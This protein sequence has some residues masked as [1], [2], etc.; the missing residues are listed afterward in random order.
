[1]AAKMIPIAHWTRYAAMK[2]TRVCLRLVQNNGLLK[3]LM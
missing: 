3:A 1:M 2:N